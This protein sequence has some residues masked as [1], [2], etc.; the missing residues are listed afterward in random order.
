MTAPAIETRHLPKCFAPT[1]L[2]LVAVAGIGLITD[3]LGLWI[4]VAIA[5]GAAL[6]GFLA[7]RAKR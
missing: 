1:S 4:C 3:N 2:C 7:W 6:T 5:V